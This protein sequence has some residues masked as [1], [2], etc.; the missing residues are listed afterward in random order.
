V[1]DAASGTRGGAFPAIDGT[2]QEQAVRP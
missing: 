1:D 2:R